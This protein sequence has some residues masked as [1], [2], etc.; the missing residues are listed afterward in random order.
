[1][2]CKNATNYEGVPHLRTSPDGSPSPQLVPPPFRFF[3]NFPSFEFQVSA[4]RFLL[5]SHIEPNI[6][7]LVR[8]DAMDPVNARCTIVDPPQAPWLRIVN[9]LNRTSSIF[10][11]FE[12]R[13]HA[14]QFTS[15]G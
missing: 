11:D 12:L 4:A 8:D 7:L 10:S 9:L 5:Q 3:R 15:K 1:M 13:V 2:L 6:Q 14:A